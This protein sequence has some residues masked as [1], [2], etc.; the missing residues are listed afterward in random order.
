ML[1]TS[2]I[3]FLTLYWLGVSCFILVISLLQT[4][5]SIKTSLYPWY[6]I[7]LHTCYFSQ[8][9]NDFQKKN[10][11]S[12]AWGRLAVAVQTSLLYIKCQVSFFRRGL[13]HREQ[14]RTDFP[15]R[16]QASRLIIHQKYWLRIRFIFIYLITSTTKVKINIYTHTAGNISRDYCVVK[17]NN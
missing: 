6:N 17:H 5:L 7:I 9:E 4:S 15:D 14:W 16:A 11:L 12:I 13:K 3:V 2:K 1:H 8:T 10:H